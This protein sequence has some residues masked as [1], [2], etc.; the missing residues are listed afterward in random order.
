MAITGP[1]DSGLL[2]PSSPSRRLHPRAVFTLAP[3]SRRLRVRGVFGFAAS[4]GSR[5]LRRPGRPDQF[6]DLA[7]VCVGHMCSGHGRADVV[8]GR[9]LLRLSLPSRH[10]FQVTCS[11]CES[12]ASPARPTAALR[13]GGPALRARLARY[14]RRAGSRS[15]GSGDAGPLPRVA[16]PRSRQGRSSRRL[17]PRPHRRKAAACVGPSLAVRSGLD[18]CAGRHGPPEVIIG[19]RRL[20]LQPP[21]FE[22]QC[23]WTV[24]ESVLDAEKEVWRVDAQKPARNA[25]SRG[26]GLHRFAVQSKIHPVRLLNGGH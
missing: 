8:G 26:K 17:G 15:A 24:P 6:V 16:G 4:S 12:P 1:P 23:P 10:P 21:S 19:R 25:K 5:R 14:M 22:P 9:H 3:S 11:A 20:W 18:C 13:A 7:G 2:A